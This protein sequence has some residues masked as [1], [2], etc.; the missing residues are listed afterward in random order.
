MTLW[1]KSYKKNPINPHQGFFPRCNRTYFNSANNGDPAAVPFKNCKHSPIFLSVLIYRMTMIRKCLQLWNLFYI[2]CSSIKLFVLKWNCGAFRSNSLRITL[3]GFDQ[4]A[5]TY[6]KPFSRNPSFSFIWLKKSN[7]EKIWNIKHLFP[8]NSIS[9]NSWVISDVW[10]L[11]FG[12]FLF[13]NS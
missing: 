4:R 2:I 5:T 9:Q 13:L 12:S 11:E 3:D 1:L 6:W 7:N 10:Y 8:T